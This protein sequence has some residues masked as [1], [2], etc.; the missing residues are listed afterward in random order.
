MLIDEKQ[1]HQHH[2][3]KACNRTSNNQRD[4]SIDLSTLLSNDLR[5]TPLAFLNHEKR[6]YKKD[7]SKKN[8]TIKQAI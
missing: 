5:F 6:N 4:R 2:H 1:N 7:Y 8:K 3:D